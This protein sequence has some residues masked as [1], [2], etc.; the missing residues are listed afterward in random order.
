LKSIDLKN[1][2][3]LSD[4]TNLDTSQLNNTHEK[5]KSSEHK[6]EK[7]DGK[8]MPTSNFRNIIQIN[9]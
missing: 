6:K 7:L 8:I 4:R 2:N 9:D 3:S 5:A 1:N